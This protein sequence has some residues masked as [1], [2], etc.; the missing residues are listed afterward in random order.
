MRFATAATR[1]LVSGLALL[2][3]LTA[4]RAAAQVLGGLAVAPDGSIYVV[5]NYPDDV[6]YRVDPQTGVSAIVSSDTV[7]SGPS[8]WRRAGPL[9]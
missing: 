6:V 5:R 9:P 7:G 2:F 3:V 1:G 8:R 4:T